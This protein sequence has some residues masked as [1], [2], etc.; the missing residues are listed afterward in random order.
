M[1]AHVRP[2]PNRPSLLCARRRVADYYTLGKCWGQGAT[3]VVRERWSRFTGHHLALKSRVV[4]SR[5]A[6]EAMHN[7]LRILQ[8]CAKHPYVQN[9]M[10]LTY[11]FALDRRAGV[12]LE[13]AGMGIC[14][15]NIETLEDPQQATCVSLAGRAVSHLLSQLLC[16]AS[17]ASNLL[18]EMLLVYSGWFLTHSPP[19]SCTCLDASH[20]SSC[21]LQ[22]PSHS[23]SA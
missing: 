18:G 19:G 1:L 4:S 23:P 14:Q 16:M 20:S 13:E 21:F 8:L 9:S 6:T 7:E 22:A 12:I 5:E 3:C 11:G 17:M 15:V 10:W 2:A